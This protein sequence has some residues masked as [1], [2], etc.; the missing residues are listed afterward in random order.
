MKARHWVVAAMGMA[1]A[2]APFAGSVQ[3]ADD[4]TAY[5]FRLISNINHPTYIRC[6]SSGSWTAVAVWWRGDVSCSGPSAQTK[7]GEGIVHDWT[8]RCPSGQPVMIIR[9]YHSDGI[10]SRDVSAVCHTA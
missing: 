4:A 2:L 9:Y 8:Y 5:R 10:G 1:A 6:G 3:A 7:V